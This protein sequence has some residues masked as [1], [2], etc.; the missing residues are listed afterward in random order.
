MGTQTQADS[1]KASEF[2]V[3]GAVCFPLL[4]A[5][6][7]LGVDTR[8]A[9]HTQSPVH[10]W[11]WSHLAALAAYPGGPVEYLGGLVS[12][13]WVHSLAGSL[14][15]TG[16]A[17]LL[18]V[19]TRDLV[20]WSTGHRA[21][22]LPFVPPV[23][24]AVLHS[25]YTHPL[26]LDLAAL[27]ALAGALA[28]VRMPV[29]ATAARLALFA[30]LAV[31]VH[32]LA[33]GPVLVMALLCVLGE[34]F[35]R[36]WVLAAACAAVAAAV[37]HLVAGL[38]Q[39]R[40]L[41]SYIRWLPFYESHRLYGDHL[42]AVVL[43]G[44]YG[45]LSIAVLWG[46]LARRTGRTAL[47][48]F[49]RGRVTRWAGTAALVVAGAAALGATHDSARRANAEIAFRASREDWHG[50]LD[51]ARGLDSY[52]VATVHHV[53]RALANVGRLCEDLFAYPLIPRE[54]I[55]TATPDVSSLLAPLSD[56]FFDLGYVNESEH[57]AHEY[58][59]VYGEAPRMLQRLAL[60]NIAKG[61]TE[62]ARVFL[63]RLRMT[64]H[65]H[66]WARRYAQALDADPLLRGDAR[67]GRLR[68]LMLHRDYPG[69]ATTEAVLRQLL[70]RNPRNHMAF[71]YLMAHYLL[72]GQLGEAA[73]SLGHLDDFRSEYGEDHIPVH[74]EEAALLYVTM[75]RMREGDAAEVPL[76]DRQISLRSLQRF[77]DF[78]RILAR[79]GRHREAALRALASSHGDTYWYYYLQ[80]IM[81]PNPLAPNG[82]AAG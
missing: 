35:R 40:S 21:G 16:V 77:D 23:L 73:A 64:V 61:R 50:V 5:Y 8:L 31:V 81:A 78:N 44:L 12:Q 71:E 25:R 62:A 22:I 26:H 33:A 37:P 13:A 30:A 48:V 74:C 69:H 66:E 45:G 56:V 75:A 20:L 34:L 14:A 46:G 79:H 2:A 39:V 76:G 82:D 63:R 49:A 10:Y 4:L 67:L 29:S 15:D 3:R 38:L 80:H 11:G 7:W 65:H 9:Y 51:L 24:L 42:P 6:L 58:L 70:R 18:C 55:F 17:L 43:L 1:G 32:Y 36:R 47:V 57:M 72:T 59:A 41:D 60:I 19:L 27:V 68:S 28:Y 54:P 53:H 52:T